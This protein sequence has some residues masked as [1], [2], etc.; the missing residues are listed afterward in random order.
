MIRRL[1]WLGGLVV[2]TVLGEARAEAPGEELPWAEEVLLRGELA[3][4]G[5]RTGTRRWLTAPRLTILGGTKEQKKVVADAV[6]HLN[7]ALRDTP[8]KGIEL[9][10]PHDGRATITVHF[11]RRAR[12]ASVAQLYRL[13]PALVK[14]IKKKKW[15]YVSSILPTPANQWVVGSGILLLP[16]DP[17]Y[18]A[19]LPSLSLQGLCTLL[20]L[21]RRSNRFEKSVFFEDG[22]KKSSE[23]RLT[24]RDRRLIVWYYNHVPPGTEVLDGLFEKHWP[25]KE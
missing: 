12:L 4:E 22:E 18:E 17:A 15:S 13:H 3:V 19:T 23:A 2:L 25:R 16:S 14:Q 5:T 6:A 24:E 11:A 21:I 8:I 10:K 1:G 9:L 7:E 20:G